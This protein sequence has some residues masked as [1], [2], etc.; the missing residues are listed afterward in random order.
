MD[1]FANQFKVLEKSGDIDFTNMGFGNDLQSNLDAN[2]DTSD[3]SI[4]MDCLWIME[5]PA[6]HPRRR[7]SRC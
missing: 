2:L 4:A 6:G 7:W 5:I 3:T 1:I